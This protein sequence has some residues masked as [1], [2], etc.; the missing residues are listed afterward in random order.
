VISARPSTEWKDPTL[1][2]DVERRIRQL[3]LPLALGLAFVVTGSGL[4]GIVRTFLTMWVHELGHA[5]AAWLCGFGAF[6]GPWFTPVSEDRMIVVT[7]LG[8][9]AIGYGG[10]RAWQ[11]GARSTCGLLAVIALVQLALTFA[12]RA[13]AARAFIVFSGDAGCLGLGTLLMAT[14]YVRPG[15]ALHRGWLRWGFLVI[16][17]FAFADAFRTWWA[18]GHSTEGVVF[19]ENLGRGDSDPTVLAYQFGWSEAQLV[20]RYMALAWVCLGMLAALYLVHLR[21]PVTRD[22]G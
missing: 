7:L 19:G 22:E 8:L 18:A 13:H 3:A 16:G 4:R 1:D 5:V 10:F 2:P 20:G 9:T 11:A 15:S 12:M 14:L 21:R 6:P 17:A